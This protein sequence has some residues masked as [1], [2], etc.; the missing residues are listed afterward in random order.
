[1][2]KTMARIHDGV[3]VNIEWCRDDMPVTNTLVETDDRPVM[4]GDTY[5]DGTFYR[6]GEKVLSLL[7]M[8]R[9]QNAEYAAIIDELYA[10]VTAE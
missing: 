10:E 6:D 3:V 1:M 4:I 5:A 2:A 8:L 9:V 7:D